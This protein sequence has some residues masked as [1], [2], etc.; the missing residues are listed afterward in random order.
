MVLA[1]VVFGV[2]M[3]CIIAPADALLTW[4][5]P[6]AG[7]PLTSP[8]YTFTNHD[9]VVPTVVIP[10]TAT[11][12]LGSWWME[13]DCNYTIGDYQYTWVK[14][15]IYDVATNI[16]VGNSGVEG[17][18]NAGTTGSDLISPN[19]MSLTD[20]QKSQMGSQGYKIYFLTTNVDDWVLYVSPYYDNT[21]SIPTPTIA[22][23]TLPTQQPTQ[24]P[25]ANPTQQPE[26]SPTIPE[27]PAV[28]VLAIFLALSLFAVIMLTIRKR[29]IPSAFKS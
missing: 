15:S 22:P 8:T 12:P 7:S 20:S 10:K 14:Y 25:T 23:T 18:A 5:N 28:A 2:F 27:F 4:I 9:Y 21:A 17:T 6:E 1:T 29:K 11:N 26:L 13:W 16:M 3:V 19:L 24:Q